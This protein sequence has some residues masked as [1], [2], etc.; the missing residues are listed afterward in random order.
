MKNIEQQFPRRRPGLRLAVLAVAAVL[1]AL[2][3]VAQ[4]AAPEAPSL[5]APAQVAAPVAAPGAAPLVGVVQ[6]QFTGVDLAVIKQLESK[7]LTRVRLTMFAKGER[8][9]VFTGRED[10]GA[11]RF[12]LT[13]S[14]KGFSPSLAVLA[15]WDGAVT[16]QVEPNGENIVRLRNAG[17]G[18]YWL[19]ELDPK[20]FG[21]CGVDD[22]GPVA[23]NAGP[24][25]PNAEAAK[26]KAAV[27]A[28]GAVVEN[29]A[30]GAIAP[31]AP[32][33]NKWVDVLAAYTPQARDAAGGDAAISSEI[34][35]RVASA[36]YAHSGPY[37]GGGEF[38]RLRLIN[39]VFTSTTESGYLNTD[40]SRLANPTD[41]YF[42]DVST[43]ADAQGADF[44]HLFVN[45]QGNT[46]DPNVI[47]F[48]YTPGRFGVTKWNA[49]SLVFAHETGHNLGCRHESANDPGGPAIAHA[50]E[51]SWD[52]GIFCSTRYAETVMW[53]TTYT[54]TSRNIAQFSD[55]NASITFVTPTGCSDSSPL[56]LG[57]AAAANNSLYIYQHRD[58][59][60]LTKQPY[61]FARSGAGAGEASVIAPSGSIADVFNTWYPNT[62]ANSASNVVVSIDAGNYAAPGRIS[63]K[64]RLQK[65]NGIG[66]VHIGP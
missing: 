60:M 40:L 33:G 41:T 43:T 14:V 66:N 34:L 18:A 44:I 27:A 55:P 23:P 24:A 26:P 45:E 15:V 54:G 5:L 63:A 42:D 8:T 20:A 12:A 46:N 7:K 3:G 52:P 50:W 59:A 4:E 6:S 37:G 53:A 32:D 39:I 65:W 57:D 9:L 10:H 47:G 30:P 64:S 56:A 2:P 21:T 48:A 36:N 51:V 1:A 25:T 17:G 22:H 61:F 58:D 49:G 31:L 19:D 11:G 62:G 38:L 29:A 16:L 35:S 28:P 13:G